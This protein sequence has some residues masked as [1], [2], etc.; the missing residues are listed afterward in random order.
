MKEEIKLS[1]CCRIYHINT[2]ETYCVSFKKKTMKE[3]SSVR[4]NQG[5]LKIKES[6]K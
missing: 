2:M 1:K 4:K 5:P 6:I 3:N